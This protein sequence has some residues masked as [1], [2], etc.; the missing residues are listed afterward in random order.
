MDNK[1]S[2][3]NI[4]TDTDIQTLNTFY[5][6]SWILKLQLNDI[7]EYKHH[8]S[9][10]T[11][12]VKY[13]HL[14]R[15]DGH[16]TLCMT[17][18]RA[19]YHKHW[20]YLPLFIKIYTL[21]ALR[22]SLFKLNTFTGIHLYKRIVNYSCDDDRYCNKCYLKYCNKSSIVFMNDKYY[23]KTCIN[24]IANET[25]YD[26]IINSTKK[27]VHIHKDIIKCIMEYSMGSIIDCC[28]C[29]DCIQFQN[30]LQFENKFDCNGMEIYYY[31]VSIGY[32]EQYIVKPFY[33]QLYR[34]F[35]TNCLANDILQECALFGYRCANKDSQ[36]TACANCAYLGGIEQ[37]MGMLKQTECDLLY[38]RTVGNRAEHHSVFLNVLFLAVPVIMCVIASFINTFIS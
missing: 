30:K 2:L 31:Q 35:C 37:Q 24:T 21:T 6:P 26:I 7:I 3:M 33:N 9:I 32:D 11:Y 27:Y 18:Q 17:L 14:L 25:F 34:I 8:K 22:N 19:S 23:C 29:G 15:N 38:K 20:F 28:H 5:F 4:L 13:I 12:H 10:N 36:G 16:F 1:T